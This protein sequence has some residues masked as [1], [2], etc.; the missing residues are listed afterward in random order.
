MGYIGAKRHIFMNFRHKR[1]DVS[2]QM[3]NTA[4]FCT[5]L[6]SALRSGLPPF[7]SQHL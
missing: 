4:P 3:G 7:G 2:S 5:A 6:C 1:D